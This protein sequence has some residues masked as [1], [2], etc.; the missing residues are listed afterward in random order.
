M[1]HHGNISL[2]G[3]EGWITEVKLIGEGIVKGSYHEVIEQ[4]VRE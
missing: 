4:M 3:G 2:E 1:D